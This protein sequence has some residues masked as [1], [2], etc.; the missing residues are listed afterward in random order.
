MEGNETFGP[1]VVDGQQADQ[2]P[3]QAAPTVTLRIEGDGL[4]LTRV[5]PESLVLQIMRLVLNPTPPGSAAD[6][7]ADPP[8]ERRVP[9]GRRTA[10]AEFYRAVAPKKYPEKLTVIGAYL[11]QELGRS[12]FTPD[13]LR[14]QFRAVNEPAPANLSRDFRAALGNGWMAPEPDDPN[15]YFVT[16]SGLDAVESRF[17]AP[18]AS[19]GASARRQRRR[20]QPVN[21][22]AAVP[23]G[24]EAE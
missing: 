10:L 14:T 4:T 24:P 1:L 11:Q 5:I 8:G 20:R 19:R 23:E 12:S 6:D 21:G 3:A 2:A 9:N 17:A 7:G 15:Q 13:E 16:Q 18:S 22:G